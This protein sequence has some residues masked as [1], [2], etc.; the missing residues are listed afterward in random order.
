[1]VI[2]K[3]VI[4]GGGTAGLVTGLIVKK[5][6]PF[7][8][9]EIVES[10]NIGIIG[11][12]EGS[13]E[14]W[15][16]FMEAC[17]IP[18][19]ELIVKTKATHKNGIRF[20]DWTRHTPD[21]FHSVSSA[22]T[23]TRYGI[24][25]LYNKLISENK[26]L[27]ESIAP[28]S[29]I[30]DCVPMINP[31]TSVNQYHFDTFL[32]NEYLHSLCLASNIVITDGDVGDVNIGPDGKIGSIELD[33]ERSISAD[34][35]IDASGMA[36]VLMSKF[37]ETKWVSASKYLQMNAAIAFPTPARE[38]GKIHP[39][40]IAQ[41]TSNGWMWE[42]PTQERRGN[43]YVYCSDFMSE[44]E[45][46][47][48]AHTAK[49]VEVDKYRSFKFDPGYLEKMWV[50]NC[51]AVGLAS[52]FVEPIEA[53]SIGSTVI[54]AR[55]IV[56]NIVGYENDSKSIQN[57]YNKKMYGMMQN[58]ISMVS[59]HY[60]SDREDS[61]MWRKQKSMD[62]PDYLAE[63]IELWSVRPPISSD[64]PNDGY[65]MFLT[66]HYYHVV[67]GQKLFN[68]EKSVDVINMFGIAS[69]V[70]D[71]Y[72]DIAINRVSQGKIDHAEA[73]RQIQI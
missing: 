48:E 64:I 13:T 19:A 59:L 22:S 54:Q 37:Q 5:S 72:M 1:L 33:G 57:F 47:Q 39:Y 6:L 43:G 40:T 31:H 17:N 32:L 41:A 11:V 2:N 14:H 7:V 8:S 61:P 4:V 20:I 38:D 65:A 66:P 18:V 49:G 30:E 45:A 53:T 63:L 62:I 55:A 46:V 73:L 24:F 29:L 28:M 67:Q 68:K 25:G 69:E 34:F 26:T 12:G 35:W 70:K 3:I 16:W 51:V 44:D 60:I 50:N 10:S 23:N 15:K 21:Y 71:Q 42:I 52:S 9:V 36:R 56:E 58:I 27:T